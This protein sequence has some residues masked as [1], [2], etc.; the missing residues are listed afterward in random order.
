MFFA[1]LELAVSIRDLDK[2]R[3][4]YYVLMLTAGFAFWNAGLG[5]A[6][7][8]IAQELLKRNIIKL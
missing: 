2:S 5:F 7:G 4:D 8:L 6:C 3:D 1:G